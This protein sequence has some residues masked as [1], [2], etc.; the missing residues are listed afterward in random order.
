M[1]YDVI[2]KLHTGIDED[3]EIKI[4]ETEM[5]LTEKTQELTEI[6]K[7]PLLI[8]NKKISQIT[9]VMKLVESLQ[10]LRDNIFSGRFYERSIQMEKSKVNDS[11]VLNL[12]LSD[13]AKS[14]DEVLEN[15]GSYLL[16]NPAFL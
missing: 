10:L 1:F 9:S 7:H 11:D 15:W 12:L 2:E 3:I 13:I 5:F 4:L 6:T 14:I 16:T 8:L